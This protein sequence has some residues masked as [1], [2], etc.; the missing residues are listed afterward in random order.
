MV[1]GVWSKQIREAS[2][3]PGGRE[4]SHVGL[5]VAML[6]LTFAVAVPSYFALIN[7]HYLIRIA[8]SYFDLPY[9]RRGWRYMPGYGQ[10]R[11]AY[12]SKADP[13]HH[14]AHE[15]YEARTGGARADQQ[16]TEEQKRRMRDEFRRRAQSEYDWQKYGQQQ[17]QQQQQRVVDVQQVHRQVLGVSRE[18][19]Q[20]EIKAAYYRKAKEN[21]PDTNK[22]DPQAAAKFASV[23]AAYLAL[24]R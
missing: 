24:K 1:T 12:Q 6:T 15:W 23:K 3:K 19:S 5:S 16:W 4:P 13:F 10:R 7:R 11:G 2:S 14:S 22:S 9:K 17:Q 18:A 8:E 21:H 20:T